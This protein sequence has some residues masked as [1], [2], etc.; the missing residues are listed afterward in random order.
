MMGQ[1]DNKYK[2]RYKTEVSQ[3]HAPDSLLQRTRQAVA[4]EE[5]RLQAEDSSD[6]RGQGLQAQNLSDEREKRLQAE[7]PSDVQGLRLEVE[8]FSE[9]RGQRLQAENSLDA[10]GQVQADSCRRYRKVFKWALPVSAAAVL[11]FALNMSGIFWGGKTGGAESGFAPDTASG[12]SCE[13]GA[14]WNGYSE[15]AA[16]EEFGEASDNEGMAG[17]TGALSNVED[18]AAEAEDYAQQQQE[19]AP[20]NDIGAVPGEPFD[21]YAEGGQYNAVK[22]DSESESSAA[23]GDSSLATAEDES[24]KDVNAGTAG[25]YDGVSESSGTTDNQENK[26][27]KEEAALQVTVTEVKKEPAFRSDSDTKRVVSHGIVFYVTENTGTDGDAEA[28]TAEEGR[29]KAYA[30]YRGKKYIITGQSPD[31]DEFLEKAYEILAATVEAP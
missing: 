23:Y 15:A 25:Q 21:G 28:K 20:G 18:M 30:E 16:E 17:G 13:A 3:I 4:E 1:Y 7:E 8:D 19:A 5:K 12:G 11:F 9:E 26:Y 29:R 14:N 2:N 24:M 31:Q 10:Q 6:E 27:R 22:S